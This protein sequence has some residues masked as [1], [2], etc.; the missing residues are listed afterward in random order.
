MNPTQRSFV[1]VVMIILLVPLGSTYASADHRPYPDESAI[2]TDPVA[3]E[4]ETVFIFTDVLMSNADQGNVVIQ[5]ENER[6]VD[7]NLNGVRERTDYRRNVTVNLDN[8]SVSG[9]I[10]DGSYVQVYG[11][12]RDASPVIDAE[13]VVVDYQGSSDYS[14]MY[15]VSLLG[16]LFAIGYFFQHWRINSRAGCFEPRGENDG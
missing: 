9:T 14:Y 10:T 1:I 4:G 6:V 3:Y 16:A 2:A 8:A 5:L 11:D 15:G 12:L 13:V 7:I